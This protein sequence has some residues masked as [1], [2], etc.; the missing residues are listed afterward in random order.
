VNRI[1]LLLLLAASAIAA[2]DDGAAT[3]EASSPDA[4]GSDVGADGKGDDPGRAAA[5]AGAVPDARVPDADVFAPD[6][7]AI[8]ADGGAIEP[9]GGAVAPDAGGGDPDAGACAPL[10]FAPEGDPQ[11]WHHDLEAALAIL[12]GPANHRGQDVVARE[13]DPELLI[14]KFAYGL[15][16]KD[17]KDE[18]VEVFVQDDAPCGDWRSLGLETTSEDGEF[19]DRFGIEDDGGRVFFAVPEALPF[20]WHPVRMLVQGDHSLAAFRLAVVRPR[21]KAVVFDID[22]TLT[23]GDLELV[24]ELLA[25]VFSGEHVPAMQ[26]GAPAV[27]QAWADRGYLIVY[28]TGRPD[29]LRRSSEQWL[30]DHG[31]PPG[32]VHLTDTLGQ[33]LPTSGGVARYKTEFLR[34]LQE[35]AGLELFAA[36]GN[37]TTDIEAYEAAGIPKERTYIVGPHAGEEGTV[38]LPGYVEHLPDALAVPPAPTPAPSIGGWW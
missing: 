23:T 21:T 1:L 28:L 15:A 27:A 6:A 32:V 7:G 31:F 34:R 12:Q 19:G 30:V 16:D 18:D 13:G 33:T 3:R 37:A 2:C 26:D 36:Y 22:G 11:G 4:A 25:Q 17:L 10:A 20:G 24:L 35:E 14:G 8:E 38:A 9:D 5:D 29:L